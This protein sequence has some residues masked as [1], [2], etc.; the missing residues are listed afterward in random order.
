[1][2]GSYI[3]N[4]ILKLVGSQLAT[5][6]YGLRILLIPAIFIDCGLWDVGCEGSSQKRQFRVADYGWQIAKW[7]LENN[8]WGL[9]V[10]TEN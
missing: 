10:V 2:L 4:F 3:E 6:S 9:Q 8:I 5:R 1:M 7:I